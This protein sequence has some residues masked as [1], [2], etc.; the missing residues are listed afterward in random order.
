MQAGGTAPLDPTTLARL[1][2]QVRHEGEELQKRM[3]IPLGCVI[4]VWTPFVLLPVM[5]ALLIWSYLRR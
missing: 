1:T 4:A 3:K 2:E 5:I